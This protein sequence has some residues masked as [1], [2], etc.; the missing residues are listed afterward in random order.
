MLSSLYG[1]LGDK[2]VCCS[3]ILLKRKQNLSEE[4]AENCPGEV[5]DL[6][7]KQ[8]ESYAFQLQMK[9]LASLTKKQF[10]IC[11]DGDVTV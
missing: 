9:K 1:L 11:G 10:Y 2:H 6:I 3:S 8:M 5:V 4:K 7:S